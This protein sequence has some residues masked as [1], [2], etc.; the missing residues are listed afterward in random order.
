LQ[1]LRVSERMWEEIT[2]GFVVGLP[3]TQSGYESIWVILD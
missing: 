1:P 3:K 2:M